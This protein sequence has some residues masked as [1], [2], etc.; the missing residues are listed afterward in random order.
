MSESNFQEEQ[1]PLKKRYEE[2]SE[3][4][5]ITLSATGE[6]QADVRSCNVDI[7]RAVSEAELHE[8]AAR[9][10]TVP[11]R[12]TCYWGRWPRVHS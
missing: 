10:G 12:A 5:R 8:G 7:G 2:N 3:E 6:E 9:P 11:V 4:A 1:A